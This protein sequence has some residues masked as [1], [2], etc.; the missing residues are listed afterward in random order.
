MSIQSINYFI[1]DSFLNT[2]KLKSNKLG[3]SSI[4][5][6][7]AFKE[8]NNWIGNNLC[9]PSSVIVCKILRDYNI[10][11]YQVFQN[12]RGFGEISEDHT[13]VNINNII[14]DTTYRQFLKSPLQHPPYFVGTY[15]EL[16]NIMKDNYILTEYNDI[17]RHWEKK[18]N[19]TNK[20]N[21]FI[22]KKI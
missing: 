7:N 6:S 15:E 1:T 3:I 11:N 22:R 14:I 4:E 2:L 17:M 13:F 9:G 12:C 16:L 8:N 19:I 10:M 18:I 21:D 20:V 5:M